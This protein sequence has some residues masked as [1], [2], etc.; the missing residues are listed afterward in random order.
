MLFAN[1][2]IPLDM[3]HTRENI[4]NDLVDVLDAVVAFYQRE[5]DLR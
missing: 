5:E 2:P 3:V 4:Y 1:G